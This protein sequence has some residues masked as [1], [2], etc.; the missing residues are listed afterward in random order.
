MV[1]T[2][3]PCLKAVYG[4]GLMSFVAVQRQN[5]GAGKLP[6][7]HTTLVWFLMLSG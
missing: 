4:S 1:T 7:R 3:A 5:F 6:D 2:S